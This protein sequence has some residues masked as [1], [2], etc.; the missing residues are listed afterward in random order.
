M[1]YKQV[2][3]SWILRNLDSDLQDNKNLGP[4]FDFVFGFSFSE[5]GGF[6]T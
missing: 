6:R 4:Y 2:I 1:K 3:Y 5:L